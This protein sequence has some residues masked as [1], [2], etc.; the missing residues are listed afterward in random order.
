M[1]RAGWDVDEY[2]NPERL[3]HRIEP[4]AASSLSLLR[5]EPKLI[6]SASSSVQQRPGPATCVAE[7][8][9]AATV[10]LQDK[11]PQEFELC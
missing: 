9:V 5:I 8:A 4:G 2:Q 1:F 7:G 6:H 11:V 10:R 3:S